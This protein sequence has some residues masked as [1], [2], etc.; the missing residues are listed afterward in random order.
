[1][2][3]PFKLTRVASL[4]TVADFRAHVAALGLN[5]PCEDNIAT[6]DS[7]LLAS[8]DGVVVNGKRIGN[9]WAIHP[10]EGWDGTT[11]GG[12]TEEMRRRWQRFG[13]SGAKLIFGGEA[14]A[15]RPDGRANPNQLII[16][17]HNKMGIAELREILVKAHQERFCNTDDLVIGFQLT[18][19]GRFCRP[20]DKKRWESRVAYR[21]PILDKKFNVTS[22]EQVWTDAQI[23]ELIQCYISSAKIA[24]DVGADFVDIKH[25][26][27]YLLHEFL[28][29]FT[30]PGKYGGSF[31]NRTRILR[32]IVAG[33]RAS[34]NKIDIG[35][36]LSAFDFVP[37]KPDPALLQ[38][39]K[40]GPGI[41]EDY[42]HCLPYRCGFGVNQ[43]NPVEYDLTETFQFADLCG[44][45]G[46]KLLNLS[47]G[48]PYYNPHIQRPAAYPPSDG[49]QP[50]H[51]PLIDVARQIDVVRQIKQHLQNA[52]PGTRNTKSSTLN[53]QPSTPVLI[54]TA[55]SYLQEYLPHVAQYVVRNGWVDM[56][57]LGRMTLSYPDMLV[58]A[59]A[60][61]ALTP[62]LICRTFSDCTTAPRNGLI[63]GC[64]PLDKYYSAKPEFAMLKE[65]KKA[66][67]A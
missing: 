7:P 25:C 30:R 35:V 54:G 17:D 19:S 24:A 62:K 50:A 13:L 27:G 40:L 21:H 61:G 66:V 14:M 31:E 4:K 28:G 65:I 37:F 3:E 43:N 51:D 44:E 10:M 38:P 64:Y 18:H 5:L 8:L 9:R 11:T 63:S 26:H 34:G 57:G 1:M 2:S 48:S 42:A 23:E 53:P 15:V 6:A 45:L 59:T 16:Q 56:I 49:Y 32:E 22:D 58:D 39:G 52:E 46:I 12:V 60:K 33:I 47:A 29:A 20:N 55:Y 67:G 41:P 36:R